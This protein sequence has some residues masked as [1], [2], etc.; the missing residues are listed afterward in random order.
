MGNSSHSSPKVSR[1]ASVQRKVVIMRGVSGSGKSTYIAKHC[2]GAE[3]CSAD[4]YF[5]EVLGEGKAYKFDASKL[6]DAH[7]WCMARFLNAVTHRDPIAR[8]ALVVVDNTNL[9]LWSFMGYVQVAE[10]MGYEIEIVRMDTPPHIAAERNLH[11]V[12]RNKV[13]DMSRRM[14]FIPPFLHLSEKV[15]KGV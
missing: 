10:A 6:G 9:Q 11:G 2:P 1:E 15:V 7:R 3:V 13:E 14:Q 4:D 5:T 8:A 12:P